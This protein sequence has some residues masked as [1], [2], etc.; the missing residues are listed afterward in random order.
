[1][2]AAL[3]EFFDC[4]N[5]YARQAGLDSTIFGVAS[6]FSLVEVH[7]SRISLAVG[8]NIECDHDRMRASTLACL[9]FFQL[10]RHNSGS[11]QT[12]VVWILRLEP[13]ETEIQREVSPLGTA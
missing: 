2:S 8:F 10:N 6:L 12:M 13:E 9:L 1:M 11:S 4:C 5:C 3:S 7:H